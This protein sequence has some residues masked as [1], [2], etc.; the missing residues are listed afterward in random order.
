V[1]QS[2]ADS[3]KATPRQVTLSFL[4]RAPGVFPIPKASSAEHAAENA[5]AGSL[6]LSADEIS[7]I[8]KA[9]RLGPKPRGLPML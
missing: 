2:I 1:L 9:F 4:A 3:H 6:T 5:G 7:A 8:D